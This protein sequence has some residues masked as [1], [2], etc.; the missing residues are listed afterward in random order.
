MAIISQESFGKLSEVEKKS[1]Q[2]DYQDL[3]SDNGRWIG[4]LT[5]GERNG[6]IMQLEWMFG[7]ETLQ[8]KPKIKTWEDVEKEN[9]EYFSRSNAPN[10]MFIQSAE[11]RDKLLKKTMATYKIATLIELGYGGAV[12]DEEWNDDTFNKFSI[13]W[14]EEDNCPTIRCHC[15]RNWSDFVSFHT[16]QQA[17]EFM[18][19]SE[20]VELVKQYYML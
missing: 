19:H 18:S 3:L 10:P 7:K 9:Q 17:E 20:N 5:T 6:A 4:S 16:Q 11:L 2:T 8:P 13:Q 15:S 1:I 14:D 12:S